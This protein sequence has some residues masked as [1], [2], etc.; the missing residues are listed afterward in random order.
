MNK[1]IKLLIES[2]FDDELFNQ[3]EEDDLGS[4]LMDQIDRMNQEDLTNIITDICLSSNT[5]YEYQLKNI[6]DKKFYVEIDDDTCYVYYYYKNSFDN[7]EYKHILTSLNIPSINMFNKLKNALKLLNINVFLTGFNYNNDDELDFEGIQFISYYIRKA[8][9]K[10]FNPDKNI[11]LKNKNCIKE[12]QNILEYN[13]NPDITVNLTLENCFLLDNI[14]IIQVDTLILKYVKNIN[15]FSF[16]KN[17]TNNI[18]ILYVSKHDLPKCNCLQGLPNGNYNLY[19][20]YE[21]DTFGT[22]EIIKNIPIQS[23]KGIPTNAEHITVEINQYPY[24]FLQYFSFEGLTQEILPK[25]TF[26]AHRFLGQ[27][28]PL[29]VQLGPYKLEVKKRTWKPTKPQYETIIKTKDWFLDCY[30][31]NEGEN[32]PY[33]PPVYTDNKEIDKQLKKVEKYNQDKQDK[34]DDVNQMINNVKTLLKTN[35]PYK[36][37]AFSQSELT[38]LKM[39]DD[40]IYYT[41]YSLRRLLNGKYKYIKSYLDFIKML[42]TSS[43]KDDKGVLLKDLIINSVIENRKQ[44]NKKRKELEKKQK[45]KEKLKEKTKEK[46]NKQEETTVNTN[47]DNNITNSTLN[48]EIYDYSSSSIA[49]FGRDSFYIKDQL[50]ALGAKFNKYLNKDGKKVP[51]WIISKK[52]QSDV[53]NIINN[54]QENN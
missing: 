8:K 21:Y 36:N 15:D 31:E 11:V 9:I 34:I 29:T 44:T 51:G 20:S 2:F 3:E 43:Y 6:K 16:I 50:K 25:F 23:L 40:K 45:Q 1:D 24:I 26:E 14:N 35:V 10:N 33:T 12:Y 42:K 7:L 18:K 32:K 52:K 41:I 22:K 46:L 4:G 47:T 13:Y 27:T 28:K 30:K 49:I 38:I 48:I 17:V 54:Y 5:F 37:N 19:I 39:T 53:E